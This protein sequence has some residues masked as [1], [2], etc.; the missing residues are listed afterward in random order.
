MFTP[1]ENSQQG[2]VAVCATKWTSNTRIKRGLNGILE[3]TA[4]KVSQATRVSCFVGCSVY[5]LAFTLHLMPLTASMAIVRLYSTLL[6][7]IRMVAY[8][9]IFEIC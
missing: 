5:Y 8:C 7:P 1:A 6:V 9:S 3:C 4:T 2:T